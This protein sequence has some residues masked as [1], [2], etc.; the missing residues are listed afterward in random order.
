MKL[1]L[2]QYIEWVEKWK[3]SPKEVVEHYMKKAKEKNS[4]YFAFV[5]FHEDYVQ[6]NL[7]DFSQKKLKSAPIGIKDIILTE[8]YETTFGSKIGTWYIPPYSSTAFQKL[9]SNWWLMI[10]KTNM[11][12]FAMWSSTK[13][14]YFGKTY[15]NHGKDRIPGW[16]SGGSAVAVSADLCLWALGTDTWWSIRQP[17]FCT[18]IVGIKPTYGRISRYGVQPLAN[19]FDQVWVFSKTVEDGKILL[20]SIA[21][22]DE[23]DSNSVDR[24]SD[25]INWDKCFDNID[26]RNFRIAL[27]KEFLW[28]GLDPRIKS[29]FLKIIDFLRKKWATVDEISLPILSSWLAIYYV[30]MPAEVST[31][32][33]RFDWIKFG[34]QSD[35]MDHESII[36]YYNEIR[37]EWFGDEAK[38]RILLWTYVLSS[39]NYEWYYLRAKKAQVKLVQEMEKLY[40]TYDLIISPTSPSLAW[41][42]NEKSDPLQEYLADL[43]TVTANICWLPAISVPTWFI[44][45]KWEKMPRWIQLMAWK[46]KEDMLFSVGN[47]IEKNVS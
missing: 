18:G 45:D 7:E 13:S 28:E 44:D 25:L 1:T 3:F 6:K 16:S 22:F 42:M 21:G 10:W 47:W 4:E 36:K 34:L 43:Y 14:S 32:L 39:A 19:S 17:A 15:N 26:I 12:E 11:D 29:E 31:N 37:S 27:P 30:L 46:R 9:E 33:S 35:S 5:R 23:S 41:K 40:K 38:R 2:K 20:Q 8:G 24:D